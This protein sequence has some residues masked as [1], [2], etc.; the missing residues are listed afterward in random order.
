MFKTGIRNIYRDNVICELI[1]NICSVRSVVRHICRVTCNQI[2]HINCCVK[3]SSL[4]NATT[5]N[6]LRHTMHGFLSNKCRVIHTSTATRLVKDSV[7][8]LRVRLACIL[9]I[10]VVICNNLAKLS[11]YTL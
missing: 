3:L 1:A 9:L 4:Q 10:H 8:K 11:W 2:L 5:S 7:K 6:I